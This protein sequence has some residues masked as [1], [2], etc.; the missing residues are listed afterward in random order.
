MKQN[1]G[2]RHGDIPLYV[3][4]KLP[5]GVK[6]IKNNGSFVLAE[7]ETTGH[8]HV[9]TAERLQVFQSADGRYYLKVEG[10]SSVGHQEHK[11]I[12][13]L[14]GIYEVG[15]EREYD[16]FAHAVKRVVD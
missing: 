3:L 5:E 2:I 16:H 9:I 11:T 7:G 14:P 1:L 6:E 12:T 15:K 8:K 10:K 4:D 13:V